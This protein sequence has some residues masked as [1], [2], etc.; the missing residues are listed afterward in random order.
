MFTIYLSLVLIKTKFYQIRIVWNQKSRIHKFIN[1][2]EVKEINLDV[3]VLNYNSLN[4][5]FRSSE[6]LSY[7]HR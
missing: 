7:N 1:I 4:I 3:K 2:F 5:S 6:K